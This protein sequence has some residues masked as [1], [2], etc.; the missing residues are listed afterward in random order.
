MNSLAQ[1]NASI[2]EVEEAN[3][4]GDLRSAQNDAQE[5]EELLPDIERE[6]GEIFALEQILSEKRQ[7]VGI[8]KGSSGIRLRPMDMN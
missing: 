6:E 2:A 1:L 8:T 5:Q 7:L 4:T 3:R